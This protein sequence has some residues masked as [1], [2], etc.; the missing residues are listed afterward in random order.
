MM[1]D[2]G[3]NGVSVSLRRLKGRKGQTLVEYAVI[4][5]FIS[6]LTITYISALGEQVRGL[7][8]PI[9]SALDA[10]RQSIE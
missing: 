8:L 2:K 1:M 6:V 7:Y 3:I 10:V 9:I 4:L 5:A